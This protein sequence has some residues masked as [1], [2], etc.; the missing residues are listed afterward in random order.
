MEAKKLPTLAPPQTPG[1][2]AVGSLG[3]LVIAVV[4]AGGALWGIV[5][6][7]KWMWERPLF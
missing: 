7:V 5:S 2:Q 4:L 3:I 1:E 6:L